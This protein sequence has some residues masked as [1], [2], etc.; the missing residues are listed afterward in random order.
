MDFLVTAAVYL[1]EK[2]VEERKHVKNEVPLHSGKVEP[3]RE[4]KGSAKR[5]R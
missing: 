2:A 4:E 3:R 5:G 1:L